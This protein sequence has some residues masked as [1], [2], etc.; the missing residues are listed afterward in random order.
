MNEKYLHN[1]KIVFIPVETEVRELDYKIMLAAEIAN[2]DTVCFVGQHNLLNKLIKNFKGGVYLGKNVFPEW[3]PCRLDYY[4]ELK[5]ND[6]SLLYYHEEGGIWI[7]SESDWEGMCKKQIDPKVLQNDDKIFC[8]GPFQ[9]SVYESLGS[10]ASIHNIGVARFDLAPEM[11]LR[12][13]IK[14]SSR[15]KEGNYILIN[16]NFAAVNHYLDFLGWYKPLNNLSRAIDQR[17]ESM[18]WYTTTFQVM[19]FFLEMLTRLLIDYPNSKFVLRPHPTESIDFYK[20]F[21]KTFQNLEITKD[22]SAPE[23]INGCKILIQNGCTTS[24]EAHMMGKKVISYYPVESENYVNITN[25]IGFHASSYE[26]IRSFIDN[27]EDLNL[28]TKINYKLSPLVNNFNSSDSSISKLAKLT[29][30]SLINKNGNKINLLSI[31][32]QAI[33]HKLVISLKELSGF[34]SFSKRKNIN[35]FRSH[36]PGFNKKEIEE[37]LEIANKVAGHNHTVQYVSKDLFIIS[38]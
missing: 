34:L 30:E 5:K 18:Y 13:L 33:F 6:F 19:G 22:F 11:N 7:G 32:L 24:I 12:K 37:K 17:V 10:K 23:W 27:L 31:K 16:T 21:F 15:V 9:K 1:K 26:Q 20:E 8:W 3:F 28:D 4:N 14:Q 35:M 25:D 36:F 2:E 29:S 38:K